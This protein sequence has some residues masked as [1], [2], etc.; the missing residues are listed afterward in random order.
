[1]RRVARA[2]LITNPRARGV[3][4]DSLAAVRTT[5]ANAGWQVEEHATH[6]VAEIRRLSIEAAGGDWDV[7]TVMGGDGTVTEAL[8]PLVGSG[9]PIG[10]IPA[11]T[12]N[13]LAGNL[14][15]PFAPDVAAAA[16]VRGRARPIDLGEATWDGGLR[17]FVVAVGA[18]FDARVM[19]STHPTRKRRWGKAAYFATA[20]A[21]VPQL[22]NVPHRLV[23]DGI[24]REIEAAEVFVANFGELV[25]NRVRPRRPV[26]PDD[27]LLDVIALTAGDPLEG[28]LGVWEILSQRAL[29]DHPGGPL[30][31]T[32]AHEVVIEA[33]PPQPFELDGDPRGNTPLTARVLPGAVSIV[34]PG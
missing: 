5:F 21:L 2:L 19:E 13:L 11:G 31:R 14:R 29:V 1:V 7:V 10:I 26:V 20:V 17:H 30:F 32:T 12:G 25:P 6:S 15:I 23:I 8:G 22:R 34:V 16:I 28:L 4:P 3:R 18:G 24:V 33:D 9:I 27:G